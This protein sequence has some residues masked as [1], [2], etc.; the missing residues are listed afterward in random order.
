[1]FFFLLLNLE[2]TPNDNVNSVIVY[3]LTLLVFFD[4]KDK[5]QFFSLYHKDKCVS[6]VD[7]IV[8]R[9]VQRAP[10]LKCVTCVCLNEKTENDFREESFTLFSFQTQHVP[11]NFVPEERERERE[12]G[13]ERER[14]GERVRQKGRFLERTK[15]YQTRSITS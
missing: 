12:E 7:R 3:I 4:S 14:E 11:S 5:T 8:D 9:I 15:N 2:D 6:M 13:R 1:M 10:L